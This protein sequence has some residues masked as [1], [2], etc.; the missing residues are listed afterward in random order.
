VSPVLLRSLV[1]EFLGT[2]LLVMVAVGAAVTGID[3]VGTLGVA[4]AFGLIL[5]ALAYAIGPVS[6]C[7]VNPAVTLGVLLSRG[8]TVTEAV[9]YWVVQLAGGIT[10]AAVLALLTS[11]FGGVTDQTGVLG[12]NDWGVTITLGGAF[13]IEVLLTFVLV[14][15]VL[16][17]TGKAGAPGFAGLAI[18]LTL[19]AVHLVGIP[20]TGTSVN[21]ARSL[22]PALFAGGEPLAHVWLFLLAPMV[23]AVLAV[24]VVRVLAAPTLTV[25]QAGPA[26]TRDETGVQVPA[27]ETADGAPVPRARTSSEADDPGPQDRTPG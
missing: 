9:A 20:L 21:P 8:M 2:A 12:A 3:D 5:L 4:L 19:A 1:A 23:G 26:A 16:L 25:E 11:G 22:G 14:A 10:G 6:G 7:H 18:G 13:V 27:E 15:V 17:V 24:P